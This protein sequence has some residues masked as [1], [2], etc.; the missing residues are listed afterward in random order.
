LS[1]NILV[2]SLNEAEIEKLIAAQ[3]PNTK[4]ISKLKVHL[5]T[6]GLPDVR[7]QIKF[8]RNLQSL[9]MGGAHRKGDDYRKA[10][11]AFGVGEKTF[12][13]AFETV[14]RSAIAF[15]EALDRHFLDTPPQQQS[16]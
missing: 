13:E 15:L 10:A 5:E 11:E 9:R 2:D 16:P 12:R 8:L 3:P 6:K 1:S 14:L 7:Q 4:G